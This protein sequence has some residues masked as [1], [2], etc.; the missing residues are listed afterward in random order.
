MSKHSASGKPKLSKLKVS[1]LFLVAASA[2]MLNASSAIAQQIKP[3]YAEF[4]GGPQW[5]G[6]DDGLGGMARGGIATARGL[7]TLNPPALNAPATAVLS[8]KGVSQFDLRNLLGGSFI[9]PDTHGAVGA[10]QFMETTNGVYAIYNKSNGALQ[11]MLDARTFWANAGMTDG[12]GLNGDAR[13]MFD[14]TSQKWIALQF[15][16][17]VADIQIAVSTTSSATG[18]WQST[19]FTGFAGGTADYPTLAIDSRGVYIG[20]NNFKVGC[21][22]ASPAANAFCGTTLNVIA[23]SDLFG[24]APLAAN[25]KQFFT[26]YNPASPNNVDRGFAIQGVNSTGPNFGMVIAAS[27][28]QND[29]IRYNINNPGTPGATEGPVTFLGLANY[30]GNN[31]ARQ[32]DGTRNIDPLDERIGASSWEQNGKIY[33]VYT[34]T[35]IGGTH[36]EVRYFVLDALTNAVIQQGAISDPNFDFYEGSLAVNQFGQ[37]VIGYN[38]SG[39]QTT[40]VNGDGLADGNVSFFARVFNTNGLGLLFQSDEL[41]LHVSDVGNYHNGSGEGL[42]AAG[43]QRW[44]DYSAVTLDPNDSQS[45]WAIGE[46]AE[47]WNNAAGCSPATTPGCTRSGGS[48]WGTWIADIKVARLAAVPEPEIYVLM[49]AGLLG[50]GATARRKKVASV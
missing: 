42:P 36:T 27:A 1:H 49:I 31:L 28:F 10:S 40:D 29:S 21:N 25:V 32:P 47:H 44:G 33:T 3:D 30:S 50:I 18:A 34:A 41:L 15:G 26:P 17:S 22:P 9:P 23:R 45:F 20:T 5:L 39:L 6:P 2:M 11:S 35:P 14:K 16:A 38:R 48:T 37:V 13:V 12:S 4:E 24:A 7:V 46:Y 19:K 43:R 8:F